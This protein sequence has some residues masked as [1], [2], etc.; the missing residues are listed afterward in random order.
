MAIQLE[1][2][3]IKTNGPKGSIMKFSTKIPI[4]K[5]NEIPPINPSN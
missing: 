4:Y 5:E 2:K 1:K 3:K